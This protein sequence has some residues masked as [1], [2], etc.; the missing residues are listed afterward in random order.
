MSHSNTQTD[1][2]V[3]QKRRTRHKR[4]Y[5]QQRDPDNHCPTCGEYLTVH[6]DDGFFCIICQ[7]DLCFPKSP[8]AIV[9]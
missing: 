1:P 7:F 9:P 6:T 3:V 8:P 5:A 2:P 4:S